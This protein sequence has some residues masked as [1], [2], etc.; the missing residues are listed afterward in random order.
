MSKVRQRY[1]TH[2]RDISVKRNAMFFTLNKYL[3]KVH[4]TKSTCKF[5]ED[6]K[7]CVIYIIEF[8]FPE[9]DLNKTVKNI[10]IVLKLHIILKSFQFGLLQIDFHILRHFKTRQN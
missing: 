2:D 5:Q 8:F 9:M 4:I 7:K 1:T 10:G 6:Y 3:C